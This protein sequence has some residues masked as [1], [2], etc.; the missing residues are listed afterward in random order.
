MA[1]Q[2][3]IR[4]FLNEA[5][6]YCANLNVAALTKLPKDFHEIADRVKTTISRLESLPIENLTNPAL[7]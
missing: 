3:F 5:E 4:N 6:K 1:T 7:A 2:E